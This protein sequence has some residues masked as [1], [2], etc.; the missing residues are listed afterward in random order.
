MGEE[1]R[2]PGPFTESSEVEKT[3][4]QAFRYSRTGQGAEY[5]TPFSSQD[6]VKV[7]FSPASLEQSEFWSW[8]GGFKM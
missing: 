7:L 1:H 6:K 5:L 2:A 8:Y 3:F 4:K